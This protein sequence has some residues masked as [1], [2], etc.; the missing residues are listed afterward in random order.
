MIGMVFPGSYSEL[1][2]NM[3]LSKK[4]GEPPLTRPSLKV[5]NFVNFCNR[6]AWR[7]Q[8]NYTCVFLYRV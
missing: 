4:K 8:C 6:Y 3:I 1:A 5:R 2:G 7:L